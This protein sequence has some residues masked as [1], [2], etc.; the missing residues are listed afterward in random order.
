MPELPEIESIKNHL[1]PLLVGKTIYDVFIISRK[2]V[3]GNIALLKG[4]TI[5]SLSRHGKILTLTF[6]PTLHLSFHLKM[7]GQLLFH[8]NA[9]AAVFSGVIPLNGGNTLPGKATRAY[10]T[11]THGSAL[12]FNDSR[13]FGWAKVT[14]SPLQMPGPDALSPFFTKE[15][16]FN[17]LKNRRSPIKS[18]LL[19]QSVVAGVGNIYA[20]DALWS[21]GILPTRPANSLSYA[22]VEA[23]YHSILATLQEGIKLKG[24][25]SNDETYVLP[26]GTKGAYQTRYKVYA[27]ERMPCR[28]CQQAIV[29]IKHDGRSSFYCPS[30]QT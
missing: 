13:G 7:S 8:T 24:T 21:A 1:E 5:T 19:N 20:N 22:Q 2:H 12:F 28:R 25:S 26:D 17:A 15:G 29:R 3:S 10:L 16:F 23:L 18:V 9:Q 30:C 11:F 4:K 14:R 27:R 6:S